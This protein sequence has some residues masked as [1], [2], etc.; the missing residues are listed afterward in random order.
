MI[1]K[2]ILV[3]TDANLNDGTGSGITLSNLFGGWCL[4]KIAVYSVKNDKVNKGILTG[5]ECFDASGAYA[6]NI[7]SGKKKSKNL[8]TFIR[9]WLANSKIRPY[10][11]PFVP[12]IISNAA[13]QGIKSFAPATIFAPVSDIFS[14]RRVLHIQ[15]KTK[16]NLSIIFFD[17]LIDRYDG[18]IF[19]YFFKWIHFKFLKQIVE[20]AN[21]HYVCSEAMRVEYEKIFKVSFGV[22]SN[23]VDLEKI[24]PF[25]PKTISISPLKIVYAGTVNSKNVKNLKL[26]ADAVERISVR[27]FEAEFNLFTTQEK[28][29]YANTQLHGFLEYTSVGLVPIDDSEVFS[30]LA[31]ASILYIPLD[32]SRES[33]KS[34][35]LSYLTKQSLYM[36]LG[37]PLLVHGPK[38]IHVVGHALLH[39]YATVVTDPSPKAIEDTLINHINCFDKFVKR[40]NFGLAYAKKNHCIKK[41]RKRFYD[42][43]LK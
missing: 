22:I 42:D 1:F 20:V 8:T 23:P 32:F 27:G 3:V 37:I 30:I 10:L 26:M 6:R 36:S 24:V 13:Q 29:S 28:I 21:I 4:D 12:V 25:R 5:S 35:R 19:S 15:K 17:D 18:L 2:K 31:Q 9:D 38:S 33:V 41:V 43:L 11:T 34:I 39:K 16:A 14:I 40:T 7:P